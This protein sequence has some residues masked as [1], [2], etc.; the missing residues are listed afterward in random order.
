MICMSPCDSSK[1]SENFLIVLIVYLRRHDLER[2]SVEMF[3]KS[4][5]I[6]TLLL[7]AVCIA[8]NR[9]TVDLSIVEGSPRLFVRC[10][11]F[12]QFHPTE[13]Q[14]RFLVNIVID[15]YESRYMI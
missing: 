14:I 5:C 7:I 11:T 3:S 6:H 4:D 12:P 1:G 13:Q 10:T 2:C 15:E 8:L 9:I